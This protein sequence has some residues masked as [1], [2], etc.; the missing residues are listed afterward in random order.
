VAGLAG[1]AVRFANCP[2]SGVA[3]ELDVV[4]LAC[5]LWDLIDKG[6]WL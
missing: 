5:T 4:G 2:R 6:L 3:C 1:N